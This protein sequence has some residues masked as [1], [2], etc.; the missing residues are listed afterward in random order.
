M[1]IINFQDI[2]S[3]NISPVDCFDWVSRIIA[4]KNEV[5]LPPKTHMAIPGNSFCNVMP[6]ILN[7]SSN[8][9][10]IKIVTRYPDRIPSLDSNIILLDIKSGETVAYMDGNWITAMRTGAVA[11][12][13]V[14]HFA[15]KNYSKI[16]MLGLGNVARATLLV[17][18]SVADREL[19]I[20][21]LR[22]KDQAELFAERFSGF[23]N[24][25]FKIADTVEELITD[26]DVVVS[27]VTYLENDIAGDDLYG[28]GILLVPVHTR[29]FMNCDLFFD[30]I[31]ADDTGHV[32]HFKYF[33]RYKYYA[34]VSDVINGKAVGREND[35][36]RIIAYNIGVAM[37]DIN[38]AAKIYEQICGDTMLSGRIEDIDMCAPREKFWI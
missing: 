25:H 2:V 6:C 19:E 3:L 22:Y 36:E 32:D 17:L 1:K 28:K 7:G 37:H 26:T 24:L 33:S 11:A 31:Y 5:L 10:G 23:S 38:F 14:V 8:M 30:K 15:K 18:A 12:H 9:G 35:E 34:E 20:K 27:C 13:S 29:G 21:L 4:M 16:S